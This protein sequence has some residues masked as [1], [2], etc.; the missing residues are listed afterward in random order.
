[1]R[2][3]G[4]SLVHLWFNRT[5][6]TI[7]HCASLS[8]ESDNCLLRAGVKHGRR[9]LRLAPRTLWNI[10]MCSGVAVGE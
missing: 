4:M 2:V 3:K 8:D 5:V 6:R 10:V 7:P 9:R 1:M